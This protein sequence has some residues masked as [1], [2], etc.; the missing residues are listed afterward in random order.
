MSRTPNACLLCGAP[1]RYYEREREFECAICHKHFPANADCEN[2]HFVCDGCHEAQGVAVIREVC[3][4]SCERNPVALMYSIME[5]PAIYIHGPEHHILVGAALLSAYR[6]SGGALDWPDTL[7]EMIRRGQKVPGGTCGFWGCCGAAVSAGMFVSIAAGATPLSG[8]AW[9]LANRMTA[10]ALDRI[11][12]LGGPR[13]CKRDSF[14]AVLAAIEFSEQHLGVRMEA[15][16]QVTCSFFP[17]NAQCLGRRCPYH[18]R[19]TKYV[20]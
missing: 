7:E 6:N 2:G 14:T 4:S 5:L 1:L 15:P 3:L 10:L 19:N 11:G 9:G 18:P 16:E 17:E 12:S 8:E 13:C 20:Q